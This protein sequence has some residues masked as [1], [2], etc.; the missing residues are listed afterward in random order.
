MKIPRSLAVAAAVAVVTPAALFSA[1]PAFAG[2]A[3]VGQTQDQPTYAELVKAAEDAGKAYDL[4]VAA[5]A[6]GREELEA[7]LEELDSDTHPLKAAALDT[8]KAAKAAADAKAAAEKAV[9]EAKA[10][11]EAAQDDTERSEAQQALDAAEGDLAKAV[12]AQQAADAAARKAQT[13]LDDARVAAVRTYSLLEQALDK[14]LA[15][16][17]AA[18]K[19]LA[20]AK[21]CV[22]E[23]GLTSLAIGL[24]AKLVA[25]TTVDFTL[26]VT[27]GTTR[28]LTVDPLVSFH[29]S[30]EGAGTKSVLG[31]E[32][33]DGSRWRPLSG[34]GSEHIAHVDAMKPG[35]HSD[36]KLRIKADSPATAKDA[37]ALFAGD[38]SDAYRPCVLGPM[39]RYDFQVLPAG[40]TTEPGGDAEPAQPG[41]QDDTRP[42]QVTPGQGTGA[43]PQGGAAHQATQGAGTAGAT[44]AAAAGGDG[45]ATLAATGSSSATLPMAGVGAG[46]VVLGAGAVAAVRRRRSHADSASATT[47]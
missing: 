26:R 15:D 37:L 4:A 6:K 5:K 13:A 3:A 1:A 35:E 43:R 16:K 36:V 18:D 46:A 23:A 33:S 42:G 27:N 25:G 29:V 12:T 11:L 19:A 45:G 2:G 7:T 44:Q 21:E 28:T 40:S 38:A 32:W 14:A 41:D 17:Q 30:G 31:V 20:A 9:T 22:R 39:K 34:D 47:A 24:P 8:A 10:R